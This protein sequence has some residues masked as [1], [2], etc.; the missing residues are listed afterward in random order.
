[1]AAVFTAVAPRQQINRVLLRAHVVR[2]GIESRVSCTCCVLRLA[3]HDWLRAC[4]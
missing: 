1:M 2:G 3:P 4:D